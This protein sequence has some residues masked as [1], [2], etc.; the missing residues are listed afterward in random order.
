MRKGQKTVV[1]YDRPNGS[2]A[3]VPE[4]PLLNRVGVKILRF[5]TIANAKTGRIGF[6]MSCKRAVVT[7]VSGLGG[8]DDLGGFLDVERGSGFRVA[9]QRA[10][11]RGDDDSHSERKSRSVRKKNNVN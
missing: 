6:K 8:H 11:A 2:P 5:A 10:T 1:V 7:V 4:R 9:W 3:V